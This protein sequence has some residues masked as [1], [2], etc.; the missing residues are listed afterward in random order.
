MMAKNR[1]LESLIKT[2]GNISR[3]AQVRNG[4][5]RRIISR[6][7]L[8]ECLRL[9]RITSAKQALELVRA[10]DKVHPGRW[11]DSRAWAL[12]GLK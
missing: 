5:G 1:T 3:T 2:F 7:Y 6:S 4:R 9:Q 12:M 10:A 8:H 11:P